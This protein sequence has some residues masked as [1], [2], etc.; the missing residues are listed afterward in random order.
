MPWGGCRH[1]SKP[2]VD[3]GLL[4]REFDKHVHMLKDLANYETAS[5]TTSPDPVGL[6]KILPLLVGLVNLEPSGEIHGQ[7]LRNALSTLLTHKPEV[8]D[9]QSTGRVWANLRC[10]RITT[11]LNHLRT[12]KRDDSQM[13]AAVLLLTT[14]QFNGLKSLVSQIK[15]LDEP[16]ANEV[17]ATPAP[18]ALEDVIGDGNAKDDDNPQHPLARTLKAQPS[19]CSVDS[20]GYP[21]MLN[22]PKK[23]DPAVA[24]PVPRSYLRKLHGSH[25]SEPMPSMSWEQE[26]SNVDLK[27][28][29]G[30]E[31]LK[32][33][34]V[35]KSKPEPAT[36]A[37]P[38]DTSL[39]KEKSRD[40]EDVSR[41]P[42][43]QLKTTVAKKPARAYICGSHDQKGKVKLIVEITE[44]RS[45]KYMQIME[46]ILDA[47]KNQHITKNEALEMRADLC[48]K[49]P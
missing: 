33:P 17:A 11:I 36:D 26:E 38:K 44:K 30:Y 34:A 8:N 9:Y 21:T 6:C 15:L 13:K 37:L 20:N 7:S 45:S 16:P 47:L 43:L 18:P 41:K 10:E 40:Q 27:G 2:H 12:L 48:L 14:Q 46:H 31:V 35:K 29:L 49:F 39:L 4:F 28:S 5:R 22:S 42:W 24:A 3:P 25:V 19:A 32:R 1:K 23:S